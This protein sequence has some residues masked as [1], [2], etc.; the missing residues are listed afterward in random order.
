MQIFLDMNE[1]ETTIAAE[2]KVAAKG[3]VLY[4]SHNYLFVGKAGSFC[5]IKVGCGG[6][7]LVKTTN[8]ENYYYVNGAKGYRW[9]ESEVVRTMEKEGD[10]DVGYYEELVQ[11]ARAAIENFGSFEE[12]VKE[13]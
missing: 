8:G 5:P 4:D 12:F 6:G 3:S 11:D 7:L 13:S 2:N 10:V 1:D 9:L